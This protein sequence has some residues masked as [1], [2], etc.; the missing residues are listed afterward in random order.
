MGRKKLW[1]ITELFHPDETATAYILTEYARELGKK[2]DL[3]V[4]CA[5]KPDEK[6]TQTGFP[7]R[8]IRVSCPDLNKDKLVQRTLRLVAVSLSLTW[9]ALRLCRQGDVVLTVTNPAPILPLI[10]LA[11]RLKRFRLSVLVHDVFPENAVAAGIVKSPQSLP[12]RVVKHIFDRAYS[13]ADSLIA[14]GRDMQQLLL[15][16]TSRFAHR[17]SVSMIENWAEQDIAPSEWTRAAGGKIV[18]QY[19]GNLGRVQGLL[20]FLQ[21]LEKSGNQNLRFDVYGNGAVAEEIRGYVDAHQMDNVAFYGGYRRSE[22]NAILNSC[23]LSLISLSDGMLGLG[24]P[25]KSYNIMA[26][27]NPILYIGHPDSEMALTVKETGIGYC[28]DSGDEDGIVG[29]LR[30]LSVSKLKEL[31]EK[32]EMARAVCSMRYTKLAIMKKVLDLV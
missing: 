6:H 1:I 18:L 24:V 16:K 27:G 20:H 10:A 23:D 5:S 4:V 21:L 28:F 30:S 3:T 9:K 29:F 11:K 7:F 26:A 17:P 25:S 12:Y 31:R 19:A 32:G 8:I 13:V 14:L 2:Y 22:Q 15:E